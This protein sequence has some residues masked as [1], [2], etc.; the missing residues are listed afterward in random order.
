M[1]PNCFQRDQRLCP[2]NESI[3]SNFYTGPGITGF[4]TFHFTDP[5]TV[6]VLG[7]D[8]F[9]NRAGRGDYHGGSGCMVM[10]MTDE[11]EEE[12]E[13][14]EVQQ[15]EQEELEERERENE[16]EEKEEEEEEDLDDEK[17]KKKINRGA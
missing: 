9:L 4:S 12:E 7:P 6:V 1:I 3:H 13:E 5:C 14:E 11:E 10:M 2:S 17:K 15:E 16:I 8:R